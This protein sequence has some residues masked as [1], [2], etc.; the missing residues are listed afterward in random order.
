MTDRYPARF[1]VS[2][3]LTEVITAPQRRQLAANFFPVLYADTWGDYFGVW[4]WGYPPHDLTPSANDRLELESLAG[5]LPTI[6]AA[7]GGSPCWVRP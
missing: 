1:Y 5:L 4:E 2:P 6:V 3:G 7:A